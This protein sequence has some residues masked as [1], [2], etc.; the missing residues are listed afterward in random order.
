MKDELTDQE[1]SH[2]CSASSPGPCPPQGQEGH[3]AW[4]RLTATLRR[5]T[6]KG[7]VASNKRYR[8]RNRAKPSLRL[9]VGGAPR[10]QLLVQEE[11]A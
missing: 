9:I 5:D 4:R 2:I 1:K 8:K 11:A 3:P 6:F 10:P 7:L